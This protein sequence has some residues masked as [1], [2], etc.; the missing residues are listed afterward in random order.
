MIRVLPRV[1]KDL[2]RLSA[3]EQRAFEH[4]LAKFQSAK[5][6]ERQSLLRPVIQ[7]AFKHLNVRWTMRASQKY[8][9]L[10]GREGDDYIVCGFVSRGDK[11]YYRSE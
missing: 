11:R 6:H 3:A 4:A 8:R 2:S 5:P 1:S 9:V 7:P 10:V